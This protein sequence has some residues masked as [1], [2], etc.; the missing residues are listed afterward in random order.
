MNKIARALETHDGFYF[1]VAVLS[2]ALAT[3][4][5]WMAVF[6]LVTDAP[7]VTVVDMQ[8]DG[9]AGTVRLSLDGAAGMYAADVGLMH[10]GRIVENICPTA[11]EPCF[12]VPPAADIRIDGIRVRA[13][14]WIS[15]F[16]PAGDGSACLERYALDFRCSWTNIHGH[17]AEAVIDERMRNGVVSGFVG[18]AFVAFMV[19]VSRAA[20]G[21]D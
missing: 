2:P 3:W 7:D 21:R 5:I 15:G 20:G 17:E 11:A 1:C 12:N 9:A 14:V 6:V 19:A 16:I 4:F 13:D 18:A 10:G 8:I